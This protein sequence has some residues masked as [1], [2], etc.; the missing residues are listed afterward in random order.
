[1]ARRTKQAVPE[2]QSWDDVNR[3]LREIGECEIGIEELEAKMN[4]KINDAKLEAEKLGTP[5]KNAIAVRVEQIEA[6]VGENRDALIGKSKDLN[7][8]TV[9]YRQSTSI[10]YSTRKTEQVLEKLEEFGMLNC[11]LVKRSVNKEALKLYP[12]KD[13]AKVGA[14]RK[15][16]DKFYCEAD[17]AKLRS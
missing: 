1:M 3:A 12:D 6:F 5:L 10:T 9:G 13:I 16:E 11:I 15:I 17:L 14:R 4:I 7:F 8:G 2:L